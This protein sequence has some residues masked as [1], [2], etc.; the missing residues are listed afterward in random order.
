MKGARR[1]LENAIKLEQYCELSHLKNVVADL[2]YG[3]LNNILKKD[4]YEGFQKV[5]LHKLAAE[6]MEKAASILWQ[7]HPNL[8]FVIFDALRP[9]SAQIQ[10][11]NLVKGTPQ[12]PYFADP[13]KGS[14][15]SYGFAVDLSLLGVDGKELDM[16]TPF[17]DLSPLAEP[18]REDEFLAAGKLNSDQ[19]ANRKILRS[20]MTEAGF[21]Q[22]PHEWWHYDALP[23]EEVRLKYERLE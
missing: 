4:V 8:K 15:H 14:V 19:I 9:Q 7:K 12:Q 13:Q 6:K 3:S 1:S 10:F 16:G 22:L 17:D 2:R 23:P 20:V 5:V 11:W 18:K 21:M